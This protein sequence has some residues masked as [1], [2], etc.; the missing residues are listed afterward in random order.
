MTLVLAIC[1]TNASG[2]SIHVLDE[3]RRFQL[4]LPPSFNYDTLHIRTRFGNLAACTFPKTSKTRFAG[5]SF[6]PGTPVEP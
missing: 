2:K 6:S 4:W 1:E 5:L 3:S